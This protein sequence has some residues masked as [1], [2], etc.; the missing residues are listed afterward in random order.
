MWYR[1][2]HFLLVHGL[3]ELDH[4]IQYR[5]KSNQREH[6]QI[7]NLAGIQKTVVGCL[8]NKPWNELNSEDK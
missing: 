1:G 4:H 8:E 2:A 5:L 3:L 7:Q 6:R